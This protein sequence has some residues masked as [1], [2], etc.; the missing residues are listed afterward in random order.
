MHVLLRRSGVAH[1]L[2]VNTLSNF[3]RLCGLCIKLMVGWNRPLYTEWVNASERNASSPSRPFFLW[4]SVLVFD[5]ITLCV[6]I[7]HECTHI[8]H[9]APF[10]GTT[11]DLQLRKVECAPRTPL[12]VLLNLRSEMIMFHVRVS[13]VG[14]RSTPAS[15]K[16]VFV[17]SIVSRKQPKQVSVIAWKY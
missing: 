12:V 4:P 13:Q 14:L 5:C 9:R 16:T 1:L 6:H 15:K 11:S 10:L 3:I 17:L 8:Y 2:S 7:L